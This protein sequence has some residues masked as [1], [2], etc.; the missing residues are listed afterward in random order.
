L[1]EPFAHAGSHGDVALTFAGE[2]LKP[3]ADAQ[4]LATAARAELDPT[5]WCWS[6]TTGRAKFFL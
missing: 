2:E 5:L 1:D 6:G 4:A 3:E